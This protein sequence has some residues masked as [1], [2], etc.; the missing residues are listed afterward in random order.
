[1]AAHVPV[2][3]LLLL[4][5][6][7]A[8]TPA[9]VALSQLANQTFNAA[10]FYANRNG[11]NAV[12]NAQLAASFIGAVTAS[13]SV[14]VAL[15]RALSGSPRLRAAVPFLAAAAAKPVQI[16]LMR[17]DEVSSGVKVYDAQGVCVGTSVT[18]GRAAVAMTV[19]TRTIYLLP[20]LYLPPLQ[21]GLES[22]MPLL[23]SSKAA[24]LVSYAAVTALSSAYVTPLCMAIFDQ[25]ASM[26]A[27][28]L[29][30]EFHHRG[31]Q[32]YFNKGL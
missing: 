1:M 5:M 15:H 32:L 16:G 21:R 29:E 3:T 8:S 31:G 14:G 4:G 7:T 28:A 6:L 24:G 18:A 27:T 20:M 11:S 23:R 19:A 2:N 9:T 26:N 22:T 13:I 17:S 10:Q 30:D 25:R 12:S